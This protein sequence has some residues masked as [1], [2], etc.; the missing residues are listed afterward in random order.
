MFRRISLFSFGLLLLASCSQVNEKTMIVNGQVTG[1]KKGTIYLERFIDSIY[2]PIDST[3]IF[4]DSSFKLTQDIESPEVLHLHL[5]LENGNLLEDR[6]S[7]FANAGEINLRTKLD[8]FS[9]ARVEGSENH[10]LLL[11]YY[12][13]AKRY[14]DRNLDLIVEELN[15]KKDGEDSLVLEIEERRAKLIQS[16]YLAT[17]NFALQ[18]TS[19]DI[20][21]FLMVYETPGVNIKY[22]D[23]VYNSL[24]KNIKDNK[25]GKELKAIIDKEYAL[26]KEN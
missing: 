9:N 12:K 23:T 5:R 24:D 1:L 25:Y 26:I 16:S 7:F 4:G 6:V 8:D 19:Q 14:A 22:L 18:N 15:A 21:P 10:E 20:A 3:A 13:I 17:I 2:V 11:T